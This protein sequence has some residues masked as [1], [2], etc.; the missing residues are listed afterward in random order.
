MA[1]WGRMHLPGRFCS[2][3]ICSVIRTII[4][5]RFFPPT[6][7]IAGGTFTIPTS[8]E[9]DPDTWYRIIFTARDSYGLS[10][11]IFRDIFPRRVHLGLSTT[12]VLFPVKLDGS[13]KQAPYDLWSVVHMIRNIGVDTPQI[14]NGPRLRF[15]FRGQTMGARFHNISAPRT[16]TSYF[17]HFWKRPWLR[18]HYRQPKSNSG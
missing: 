16:S 14:V 11:T 8:G 15:R 2:S 4:R 7:G 13:P 3:I 6:S 12:P 5:T 17:A 1:S 10:T 18:Q 9:T